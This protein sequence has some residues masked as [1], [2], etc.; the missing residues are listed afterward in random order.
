LIYVVEPIRIA[1]NPRALAG[2][3]LVV[4]KLCEFLRESDA[5]YGVDLVPLNM[6]FRI[7]GSINSKNDSVVKV[8]TCE[9]RMIYTLEYFLETWIE[10]YEEA[11][12]K[13]N[14]KSV[15]EKTQVKHNPAIINRSRLQDLKKIQAYFNVRGL[16]YG[17]RETLL[18]LFKSYT[19]LLYWKTYPDKGSLHEKAIRDLLDF[20]AD[21]LCP[22]KESEAIGLTSNISPHKKIYKHKNQTFLRTLYEKTEL[23]ESIVQMLRLACLCGVNRKETNRKYYENKTKSIKEDKRKMKQMV[24]NSYL[25]GKKSKVIANEMGIPLR[26]VQ[27][28]LYEIKANLLS[29]NLPN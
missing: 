11:K 20:N 3:K 12:A 21:F 26:T 5:A 6:Y 2:I 10:G 22:L 27:R 23:T 13:A 8:I 25:E 1:N 17:H 16:E 29:E 24:Y 19:I 15:R 18:Y 7:P 9:T 4:E 14:K 28:Y